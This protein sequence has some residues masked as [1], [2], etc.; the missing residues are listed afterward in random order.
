M[1]RYAPAERLDRLRKLLRA[2]RATLRA[3]AEKLDV[4][5]STVRRLLAALERAGE[6]LQEETL[7]DGRKA[8]KLTGPARDHT[9]RL[10]TAQLIALLVARNGAREILRGTGFDDDLDAA[11]AA[12]IDTLQ[13]KD[14]ALAKDLDRKLYDRGEMPLD[15][16]PHAETLDAVTTALFRGERLELRRRASDGEERTH[17]FDPYSLVTFKKG[18]Y[19]VGFSHEKAQRITLGIDLIL[20][21][22][23]RVGDRFTYPADYD[24]RAMYKDAIGMFIGPMT[25]VIVR[26]DKEARRYVERRRIHASQ[27]CVAEN[28]D[29]SLDVALEIAGTT[30]L[31]SVVLSYGDKA[32]VIGPPALRKKVGE[33]LRRAAGRYA[34]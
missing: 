33:V 3:L 18:F 26:F 34:G 24:P 15:H 2:G 17:L 5:E 28:A 31:E 11:C 22:T 1:P 20:E 6:P 7:D 23:R 29:G 25:S 27:K 19:F 13:G 32:E 30:E 8:W 9:V 12:L 10:T 16:A 21:A 4:S 14:A